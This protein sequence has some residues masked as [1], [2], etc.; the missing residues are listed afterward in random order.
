[1]SD[2]AGAA[3][4]VTEDA[5]PAAATAGDADAGRRQAQHAVA[6]RRLAGYARAVGVGPQNIL[7]RKR[8]GA[9]A[10]LAD[11]DG[12]RRQRRLC[13]IACSHGSL[14][15]QASWKSH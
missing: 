2:D 14:P 1:M 7:E 15:P 5:D 9:S 12:A 11:R 13:P 6:C 10:V 4:A 3:D 8:D